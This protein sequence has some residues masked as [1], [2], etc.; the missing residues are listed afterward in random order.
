MDES[1]I[2]LKI[3]SPLILSLNMV[4]QIDGVV[5]ILI[6]FHMQQD[7][8]FSTNWIS[9]AANFAIFF[10][11]KFAM[12]FKYAFSIFEFLVLISYN[13]RMSL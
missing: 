1:Y 9:R 10:E 5:I 13:C 3:F 8:E 4:F 7:F 2:R 12:K 6:V 11:I